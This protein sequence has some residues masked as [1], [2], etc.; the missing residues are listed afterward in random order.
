MPTPA[1]QF[2]TKRGLTSDYKSYQSPFVESDDTSAPPEESSLALHGV[3][4]EAMPEMLRPLGTRPLSHEDTQSS[5]YGQYRRSLPNDSKAMSHPPE[6]T[7]EA[8]VE[9]LLEPETRPISHEQLVME[10]KAIYAGLVMV[11]S[12]CIDIDAQQSA[13]AQEKNLSIKRHLENDRWQS[14]IALHRQLLN[15]HNDFFFA[16]QHPLESRL[17]RNE[18]NKGAPKLQMPGTPDESTDKI[19]WMDHVLRYAI[20]K[21]TEEASHG[22]RGSKNVA[23]VRDALCGDFEETS[24]LRLSPRRKC[25]PMILKGKTIEAQ[26]D[27]GAE[28]SNF[29]TSKLAEGLNLRI[30]TKE[31]DRKSFS[32]GTGKVQRAIGR[33]R[34][35]CAFAKGSGT[36]MKLWFY[37][38]PRLATQLIMGLQFLRDTKTMSHFTHR[39]EDQS[40]CTPPAPMVKLISATQQA[41]R[42]LVAFIDDRQTYIN[43]DS[44]SHLDLMSAAYVKKYG[45]KLDRRRECRK[46]LLLADT[47][48]AETI[49]QVKA[50]LTLHDGSTYFRMFDVLPGLMSEVLIGEDTLAELNIFTEHE[51]SFMDVWGGERHFE[52]SILSHLGYLSE[53][54]ARKLNLSNRRSQAEYQCELSLGLGPVF[55]TDVNLLVS[56]SKQHDD[57]IME[58]LHEQDLDAERR[59]CEMKRMEA[60]GAVS[61]KSKRLDGVQAREPAQLPQA[62]QSPSASTVP[63]SSTTRSQTSLPDGSV[64][65]GKRQEVGDETTRHSV[66]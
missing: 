10:V 42:R 52:L 21:A 23:V 14:L 61:K 47:T 33:V 3:P 56:L 22:K 37:V 27:T 2:S 29:M 58:T 40:P 19:S 12:K 49:G 57:K 31:S 5:A 26:H 64:A 8:E 11:E 13:A 7:P 1:M 39:L 66:H 54:L 16:S 28:G 6:E 62:S 46:R 18:S 65:S 17:A 45:Y 53:F 36:K 34:A 4:G 48:P 41:K 15:D 35:P 24:R 63:Q 50:K 60:N 59:Q 55:G 32:M 44:G 9:M 30:R 51:S 25:L 20:A 43:A 38:L